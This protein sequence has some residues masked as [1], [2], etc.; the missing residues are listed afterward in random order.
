MMMRTHIREAKRA[1]PTTTTLGQS[2]DP[3][4]IAV[5]HH[6]EHEQFNTGHA[7]DLCPGRP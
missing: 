2:N 1:P 4:A 3:T 6:Q 5:L 7:F